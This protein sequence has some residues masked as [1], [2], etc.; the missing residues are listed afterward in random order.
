MNVLPRLTLP[1]PNSL[2][3]PPE[4]FRLP[5]DG[6]DPYFGLTR[7]WYYSAEKLGKLRLVRLRDRG[8]LRGVTLVPYDAV[9]AFIR[10]QMREASASA[11]SNAENSQENTYE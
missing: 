9:S 1:H 11:L 2:A 4:F 7:S 8:K 3:H 10:A 5:T 6:P